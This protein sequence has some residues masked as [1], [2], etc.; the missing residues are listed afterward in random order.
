MNIT[1]SPITKN[2]YTSIPVKIEVHS[3]GDCF[4]EFVLPAKQKILLQFSS[5]VFGLTASEIMQTMVGFG[6]DKSLLPAWQKYTSFYEVFI[7]PKIES[8]HYEQDF[9]AT[10]L[11]KGCEDFIVHILMRTLCQYVKHAF[12]N[13]VSSFMGIRFHSI[14]DRDTDLT[15]GTTAYLNAVLTAAFNKYAAQFDLS[16]EPEHIFVSIPKPNKKCNI[17]VDFPNGANRY[18]NKKFLVD[19]HILILEKENSTHSFVK[20]EDFNL[21]EFAEKVVPND[22]EYDLVRMANYREPTEFIK[23]FGPSYVMMD[24][25]Y[26]HCMTNG[27]V[28]DYDVSSILLDYT[29]HKK[30]RRIRIKYVDYKKAFKEAHPSAKSSISAKDDDIIEIFGTSDGFPIRITTIHLSY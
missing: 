16:T 14:D 17:L 12:I 11:A 27:P 2:D 8:L 15:R 28:Y 21:D 9:P 3:R 5:E 26:I 24:E 10:E 13:A 1:R 6:M 7:F 23:K 29:S 30:Y 4:Y 19:R 20:I 25:R 22:D 18:K